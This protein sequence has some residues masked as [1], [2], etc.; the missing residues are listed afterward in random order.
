MKEKVKRFLRLVLRSPVLSLEEKS[1]LLVW[2][3]KKVTIQEL[4]SLIDRLQKSE[5]TANILAIQS[6][7]SRL[8]KR[9]R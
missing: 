4:S 9:K 5:R 8:K 7:I 1:Q 6:A 3:D 2:L